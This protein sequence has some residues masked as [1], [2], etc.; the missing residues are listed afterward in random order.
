MASLPNRRGSDRGE[1]PTRVTRDW[2]A[3]F[4][5]KA[6]L[7]ATMSTCCA[8][9]VGAVAV[10]DRH[11][12]GDGFNGNIPGAPHCDEGGC[13]RCR[14]KKESGGEDIL[15]CVCA[16][17]EANVVARCARVGHRLEGATIY[18]TAHPCADCAK[19]LIL[20]GVVEV[21]YRDDYAEGQRMV[22]LLHTTVAFRKLTT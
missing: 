2:N 20:A 15:R 3:H 16:H 12:V 1:R 6:A 11:L 18:C 9:Q 4:M 14:D 5:A 13:A 8:R 22:P 7:N 17:A 21:V 10:I 19:L